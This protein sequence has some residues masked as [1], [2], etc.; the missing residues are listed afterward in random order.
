MDSED[1]SDVDESMEM[2]TEQLFWAANIKANASHD[3]PLEL[4]EELLLTSV[5]SHAGKG[6]ITL[7]VQIHE[8][9]YVLCTLNQYCPQYRLDLEFTHVESPIKFSV[10]GSGELSL[11]GSKRVQDFGDLGEFDEEE[12]EEEEKFVKKMEE[13]DKAQFKKSQQ[14]QAPKANGQANGQKKEKAQP[15]QPKKVET[16]AVATATTTPA[17]T[18]PG[19]PTVAKAQTPKADQS[20]KKNP[21]TPVPA[22]R[23]Q[24]EGDAEATTPEHPSKKSKKNKKKATQ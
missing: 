4:G 18:T 16:P 20:Q 12:D 17:A 21:P 1:M 2:P 11:S 7:S 9:K 24:P 5:A 19:K 14:V 23:A 15:Q 13:Q 8:A 3:E 6:E 10:S 22:K